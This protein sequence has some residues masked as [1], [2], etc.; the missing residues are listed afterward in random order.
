MKNPHT[1]DHQTVPNHLASLALWGLQQAIAKFPSISVT[2]DGT[3]LP[4]PIPFDVWFDVHQCSV[5]KLGYFVGRPGS[6]ESEVKSP[7]GKGRATAGFSDGGSPSLSWTDRD[8]ITLEIT[9]TGLSGDVAEASKSWDPQHFL[10]VMAWLD[11]QGVRLTDKQQEC[12][13]R[14]TLWRERNHLIERGADLLTW[15]RSEIYPHHNA[16][17]V[18]DCIARENLR[19]EVNLLLKK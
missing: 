9:S 4:E 17:T 7:V 10:D 13:T 3:N 6:R 19:A 1:F 5:G 2:P 15:D 14:Q 12:V 16:E 8:G 11:L 18:L